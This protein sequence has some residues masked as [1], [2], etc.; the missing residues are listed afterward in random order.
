V[1]II[2]CPNCDESVEIE[3][4][5]YGRAVACPA[6]DRQF[7]PRRGNAAGTARRTPRREER[8]D[9]RPRRREYEDDRYDDRPRR[10]RDRYDEY[11]DRP[12][13]RPERPRSGGGVWLVLGILGGVMLLG[14]LGCGGWLVYAFTAPVSYPDPWVTQPLADDPGTSMQF[15][16]TPASERLGDTIS[17]DVGTK[18]SLIESP[19]KD[20][21]FAFGYVDFPFDEPGQ[22]DKVYR[23]EVAEVASSSGGRLVQ[24]TTTTV[25]G[26]P[27]KEAKLNFGGNSHGTYRLI[28]LNDRP[29]PRMLIVFVG[30]R[31]ISDA[32]QKKFLDSLKVSGRK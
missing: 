28:H 32:D 12:R 26:Y 14:C 21:G 7:T 23:L 16:R 3:D 29:Q 27:C 19:P 2:R 8:D 25:A 4:D 17:G 18:Y 22:F 6:C 10:S 5:W 11:D 20:A 24:E 15:P 1:P 30:G 31:N 13:R 9:D